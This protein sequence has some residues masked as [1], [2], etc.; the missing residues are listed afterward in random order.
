M[1]GG[2]WRH[3]DCSCLKKKKEKNVLE[4]DLPL[5]QL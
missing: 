4:F 5:S 2:S 3:E 1:W